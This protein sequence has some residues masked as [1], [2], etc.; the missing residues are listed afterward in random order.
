MVVV[1][2]K[3]HFRIFEQMKSNKLND[4]VNEFITIWK[5]TLPILM[6]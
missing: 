5:V 3:S 6:L 4:K 2:I 1:W